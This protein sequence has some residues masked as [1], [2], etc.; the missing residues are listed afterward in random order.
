MQSQCDN[1]KNQNNHTRNTGSIFI[2]ANDVPIE[3]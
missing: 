2:I 1:E 3:Y